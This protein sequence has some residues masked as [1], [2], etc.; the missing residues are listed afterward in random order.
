MIR[1]TN[2]RQ[3]ISHS[4]QT[5]SRGAARPHLLRTEGYARSKSLTSSAR[6]NA[7]ETPIK[8]YPTFLEEIQNLFKWIKTPSAQQKHAKMWEAGQESVVFHVPK[9]HVFYRLSGYFPIGIVDNVWNH[10]TMENPN[11]EP[12]LCCVSRFRPDPREPKYI[13]KPLEQRQQTAG[14]SNH[15]VPNG[16]TEVAGDRT[17]CAFSSVED[18]PR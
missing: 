11:Y 15:F 9:L 6:S 1:A 10:T 16:S 7:N 3:Y 14:D 5:S 17:R 13:R 12:D 2:I 18:G 4:F 8:R